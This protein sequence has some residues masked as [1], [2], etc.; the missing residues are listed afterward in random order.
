MFTNG[1]FCVFNL[2]FVL[3]LSTK[4]YVTAKIEHNSLTIIRRAAVPVPVAVSVGIVNTL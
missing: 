2:Y 3:H 1:G 4:R